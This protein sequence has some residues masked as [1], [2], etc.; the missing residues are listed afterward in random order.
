[1]ADY[2]HNSNGNSYE[3]ST[4]DDASSSNTT[5]NSTADSSLGTDVADDIPE[6]ELIIR[7]SF[8]FLTFFLVYT[9]RDDLTTT[10]QKAVLFEL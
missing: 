8:T 1:M 9:L 7:V 2:E 6:I 3:D 5:V 10:Y 4:P